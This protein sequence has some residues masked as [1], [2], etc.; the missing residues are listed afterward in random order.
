M[1]IISFFVFVLVI[2]FLFVFMSPEFIDTHH[3]GAG[4][5]E[6]FEL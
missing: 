1:L 3:P 2:V 5:G 4:I 6:S